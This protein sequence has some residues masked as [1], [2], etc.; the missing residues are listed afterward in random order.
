MARGSSVRSVAA[1][2]GMAVLFA[3]VSAAPAQQRAASGRWITAWATSQQ[4]LGHER[5][6]QRY[7]PHDGAG[8]DCRRGGAHSPGQHLRDRPAVDWEGVRRPADSGG[9][10]RGDS[11]RQVFFDKSATVI[12]PAGGTVTSDPVRLNVL[13]HQDL[14]VS[15]SRSWRQR[16]TKST[17]APQMYVVSD[18]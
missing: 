9:R 10:A 11:N 4:G 14:A 8:H 3:T 16:A 17:Q 18:T 15:L 2:A 12:V 13:A 7:C 5:G 1:A 6:H